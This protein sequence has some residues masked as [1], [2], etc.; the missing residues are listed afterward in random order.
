MEIALW[1]FSGCPLHKRL[2]LP[3]T[4]EHRRTTTR[5]QKTTSNCCR[6]LMPSEQLKLTFG[7]CSTLYN[8]SK[9]ILF[10]ITAHYKTSGNGHVHSRT[11]CNAGRSLWVFASNVL[12]YN[13][14]AKPNS[15]AMRT[16]LFE[17]PNAHHQPTLFR[18]LR[19]EQTAS[20]INRLQFVQFDSDFTWM[21]LVV[22]LHLLPADSLKA[23]K[24]F[25]FFVQKNTCF[26]RSTQIGLSR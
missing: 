1:N 14:R 15:A 23:L 12:M 7:I 4:I 5:S 16:N 26:N 22:S 24:G 3:N 19:S 13:S 6:D 20:R 9:I 18:L 21:V 11:V 10:E 25:R 2:Q 17:P 8:S